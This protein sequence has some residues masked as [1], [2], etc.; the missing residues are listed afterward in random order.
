MSVYQVVADLTQNENQLLLTYNLIH[1]CKC[2]PDE[3]YEE[4]SELMLNIIDIIEKHAVQTYIAYCK[5]TD[6]ED[7]DVIY[8]DSCMINKH[9]TIKAMIYNFYDKIKYVYVHVLFPWR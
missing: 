3:F 6:P 5:I 9:N 8:A 4:N 1:S 7:R 2:T